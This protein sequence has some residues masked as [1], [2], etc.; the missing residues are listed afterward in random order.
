M[1]QKIREFKEWLLNMTVKDMM[2]ERDMLYDELN[3][4]Q[5]VT[6]DLMLCIA[7]RKKEYSHLK[8]EDLGYKIRSMKNAK[9]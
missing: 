8:K 5:K 2:N 7:R 3:E 1:Q 6:T 4:L 9:G